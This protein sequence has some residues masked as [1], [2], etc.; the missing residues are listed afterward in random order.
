MEEEPVEQ[1]TRDDRERW[2]RYKLTGQAVPHEVVDAWLA[3]WGRESEQPCPSA[4]TAPSAKK[5]AF[6][7]SDIADAVCNI[8]APNLPDTV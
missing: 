7:S 5:V 6:R 2:E 3:S 1:E 4:A 8:W